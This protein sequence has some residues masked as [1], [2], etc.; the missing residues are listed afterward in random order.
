MILFITAVAGWFL[1]GYFSFYFWW[2]RDYPFEGAIK[3]FGV[4]VACLGIFVWPMGYSFHGNGYTFF[5]RKTYFGE[6]K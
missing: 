6:Q 3:H 1:I 5:G 4:L 2:S